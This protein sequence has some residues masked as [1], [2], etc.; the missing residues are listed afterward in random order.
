[1]STFEDTVVGVLYKDYSIWTYFIFCFLLYKMLV[2]LLLLSYIYW[3]HL[4]ELSCLID[5]FLFYFVCCVG[6]ALLLLFLGFVL[7]TVAL[8]LDHLPLL[9]LF[10]A[11]CRC[12]PKMPTQGSTAHRLR[13]A[14]IYY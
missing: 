6:S 4:S 12:T 13:K 8:L 10:L 1:M 2:T 11:F 3:T 14:D 7:Q 5:V 9:V